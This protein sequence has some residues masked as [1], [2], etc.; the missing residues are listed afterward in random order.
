MTAACGRLARSCRRGAR[1][2]N[3]IRIIYQGSPPGQRRTVSQP[4][5]IA[6]I[7]TTLIY[8]VKF[9]DAFQLVKSGKLHGSAREDIAGGFHGGSTPDYAPRHSDGSF[10]RECAYFDTIAVSTGFAA[11]ALP[12]D[13]S[14][15]EINDMLAEQPGYLSKAGSQEQR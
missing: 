3:A 14:S 11:R 8:D 9:C 5:P 1:G 15:F 13:Y 2:S 6:L 10:S 7:G 4:L 12:L